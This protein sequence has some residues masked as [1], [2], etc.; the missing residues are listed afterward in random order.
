MWVP[1]ETSAWHY[2]ACFSRRYNGR[3]QISDT[4]VGRSLV[5]ISLT[6]GV[7]GLMGLHK[8]CMNQQA[9][10]NG[11]TSVCRELPHRQLS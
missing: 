1:L 11:S 10:H 3:C 9:H 6:D 4:E 5:F 8:I 2:E 7:A